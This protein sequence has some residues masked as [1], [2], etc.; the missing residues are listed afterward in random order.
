MVDID[1]EAF[2]SDRYDEG[3]RVAIVLRYLADLP[4]AD[5]ASAMGCAPGTVK[6]TV[7]AA[8]AR[9]R[10]TL[11]DGEDDDHAAR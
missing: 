2:F 6:S 1:F 4:I 7:S 10:V 3:Q 9:L 8:L 5:V 11:A